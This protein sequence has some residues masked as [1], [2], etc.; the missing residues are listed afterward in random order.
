MSRIFFSHVLGP[1][2]LP[3]AAT[4]P[5]DSLT[6]DHWEDLASSYRDGLLAC[7]KQIV[8]VLRP[9]IYSTDIA[10]SSLGVLAQD[11]HLVVK[12]IEHIRPFH[13]MANVFVSDWP[14]ALLSSRTGGISPFF[15]QLRLLN[16]ATAVACCTEATTTA[17]RAAGVSRAIHVPPLRLTRRTKTAPRFR[18]AR[19][20][21][22]VVASAEAKSLLRWHVPLIQ[23]FASAWAQDSR[24]RL[25]VAVTGA[26]LRP[27]TTLRAE[28]LVAAGIEDPEGAIL[29]RSMP[30]ATGLPE[31]LVQADCFIW[32]G[33][34]FGLPLPLIDAALAGLPLIV[35]EAAAAA[36][37]LP[38]GTYI[39]LA[40]RL[41]PVET[42]DEPVV[43]VLPLWHQAPDAEA[44][45]EAILMAASFDRKILA[46]RAPCI[47]RAMHDYFG[48]EA[49]R[50]GLDRLTN[51]L[52]TEPHDGS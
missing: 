3:F 10:K 8:D 16:R 20:T 12:P 24:L 28:L 14:F 39:P 51:Y 26:E 1:A 25:I 37:G 36:V 18:S 31:W 32:E 17:L 15:H 11:W 50:S 52:S 4:P 29:V 7:G 30:V 43:Q 19:A 34:P 38:S 23:G 46:A 22:T 41:H 40:T 9:E 45:R 33:R 47:Q 48:L 13:G 6:S 5:A 44:V 2:R 35:S 49:F 21:C 27:S 42:I